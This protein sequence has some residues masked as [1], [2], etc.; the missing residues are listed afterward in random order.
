LLARIQVSS[1]CVHFRPS[2][3]CPAAEWLYS[4]AMRSSMATRRP[5]QHSAKLLSVGLSNPAQFAAARIARLAESTYPIAGSPSPGTGR[6]GQVQRFKGARGN[7]R[8][9][10]VNSPV[11]GTRY[12]KQL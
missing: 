7:A 2:I 1:I 4:L 3:I 6:A 11:L 10:D 9:T 12:L 5:K 8:L